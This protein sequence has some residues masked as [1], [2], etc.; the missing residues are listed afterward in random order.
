MGANDSFACAK[1]VGVV[2]CGLPHLASDVPLGN[3]T[4][5]LT[6]PA[7]F[8][9]RA[10]SLCRSTPQ[11]RSYLDV[12]L[13][14]QRTGWPIHQDYLLRDDLTGI[15]Y[16]DPKMMRWPEVLGCGSPKADW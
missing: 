10:Y 8:S 13:G 1:K 3:F 6:T 16:H 9:R 12:L 2:Q 5:H 7:R 11:R 4:L 14:Y 15:K